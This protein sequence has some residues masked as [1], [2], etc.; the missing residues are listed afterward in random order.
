MV[1]GLEIYVPLAGVVDLAAEA[2]RL[3]KEIGR[4]EADLT[5]VEKKLANPNFTGKAPAEVVEKERAK[6]AELS[7]KLSKLRANLA[8][9]RSAA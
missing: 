8:T 2:K 7:E 1:A 5:R 3:E 9:V 4:V 6:A